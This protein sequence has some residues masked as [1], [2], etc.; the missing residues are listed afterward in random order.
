MALFDISKLREILSYD[1]L[2]LERTGD[3]RTATFFCISYTDSTY[4]FLVALAFL[5]MFNLL[6][7]NDFK[8]HPNYKCTAEAD[9]QKNALSLDKLINCRRRPGLA[10]ECEVYEET[11]TDDALTGEDIL[12]Y[13]DFD[14]LGA[15]V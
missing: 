9:K 15:F 10:E 13:D 14:D 3:R 1:E 11:V 8:L 4:N 2:K 5:Q 12:D 6:Q 7:K